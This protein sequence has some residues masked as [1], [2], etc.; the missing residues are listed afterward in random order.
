MS[1]ILWVKNFVEIALSRSVELNGFLR[2]TQKFKMAAKTGRKMI[3]GKVSSRVCVYPV[4]QKFS[5]SLSGSI[6][7][8][9]AFLLFQRQEKSRR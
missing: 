5:K 1:L 3:F 7:E 2:L 8:I 4:C 6:S 9:N